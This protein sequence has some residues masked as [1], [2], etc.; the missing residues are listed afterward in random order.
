MW[1]PNLQMC[2]FQSIRES[3]FPVFAREEG[4]PIKFSNNYVA[5]AD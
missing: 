2:C 1:L 4:H 5:T 3:S